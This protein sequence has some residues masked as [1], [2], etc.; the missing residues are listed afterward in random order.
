MKEKIINAVAKIY[1]YT[2]EQMKRD[3]R[4]ARIVEARQLCMFI[5]RHDFHLSSI[6]IGEALDRDH[7]TVLKGLESLDKKLKDKTVMNRLESHRQR[8]LLILDC[9]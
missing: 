6:E 7:S 8:V 1:G 2:Q 4:T 3:R 5:L 9:Y